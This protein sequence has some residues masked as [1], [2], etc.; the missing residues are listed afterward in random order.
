MTPVILLTDGYIANAAEPWKVP[1]R[2][3]FEPFPVEL[4]ERE[5][6]PRRHPAALPATPS[7]VRP[8]IKPGTP[9]PDAPHR[10]H[11]KGDRHRQSRLFARQPPGA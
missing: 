3:T 7:G 11:R 4:P 8:W 1:T 5:E 10:R 9:G 6:R 2:P